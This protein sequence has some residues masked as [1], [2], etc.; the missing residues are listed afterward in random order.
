MIEWIE[1]KEYS[2]SLLENTL[3]LIDKIE[4]E[5]TDLSI[6]LNS[7]TLTTLSKEEIKVLVEQSFD[8]IDYNPIYCIQIAE[9]L[10]KQKI[11]DAFQQAKAK[12][13]YNRSYSKF[14]HYG[15]REN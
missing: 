3:T 4:V 1:L 7:F 9:H 11:A 13:V 5:A 8:T 2:K 6:R 15:S 14:N 12:K 10:N